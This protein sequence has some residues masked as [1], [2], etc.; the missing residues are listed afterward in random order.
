[1]TFEQALDEL[2]QTFSSYIKDQVLTKAKIGRLGNTLESISK[3]E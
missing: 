2:R 1:M 3:V